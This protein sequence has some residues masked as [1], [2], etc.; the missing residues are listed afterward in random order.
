M[1]K[2][3]VALMLLFALTMTGVAVGNVEAYALDSAQ[4]VELSQVW[5]E[6]ALIGYAQA[7]TRGVYLARGMSFIND[8]GGGKIGCGGIT[9][10]A[11]QCKVSVTSI[12]ERKVNG[13]W[14]QVTSWTS[15]KTSAY[16]VSIS[17]TLSVG[18]GYYYRVRSVHYAS[19]DASSSYTEGMWM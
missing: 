19:T 6:D 18:R 12:V 16:Q 8:A 5:T 1:K 2:R 4:D 13:S 10:A 14:V 11:R 3:I 15:T 17:K 7:Q 9:E